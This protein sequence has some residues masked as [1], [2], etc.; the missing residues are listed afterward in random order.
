M[1]A[2]IS[3]SMPSAVDGSQAWM[4]GLPHEDPTAL[5]YL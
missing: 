5:I 4:P 2:P 3:Y 1:Q